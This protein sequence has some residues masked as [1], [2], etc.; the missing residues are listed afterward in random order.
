M[1]FGSILTY[2]IK[3]LINLLSFII[4][5]IISNSSFVNYVLYILRTFKFEYNGQR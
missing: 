4:F 3:S 1:I 5:E 2:S